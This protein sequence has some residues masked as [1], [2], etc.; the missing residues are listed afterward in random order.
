MKCI[1][2]VETGVINFLSNLDF[3]IVH[4]HEI[5]QPITLQSF[6]VAKK[7]GKPY[8]FTQHRYSY[9]EHIL[10]LFHRLYNN[11]L[12]RKIINSCDFVCAT[13]S[14]SVIFLRDLG[15][16]REIEILPNSIDVKKLRPNIKTDLKEK[17]RL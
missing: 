14:S 15:V 11:S 16:K 9:P 8:E 5:Y 7:K 12:G 10:G 3:D 6:Y 1:P 4:A 13:S 17:T 2:F